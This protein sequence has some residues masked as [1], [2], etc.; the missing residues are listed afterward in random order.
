VDLA[1]E[2]ESMTTPNGELASE[3]YEALLRGAFERLERGN[4]H[5]AS[6]RRA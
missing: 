6:G 2:E 5:V 1:T 3:G 4:E